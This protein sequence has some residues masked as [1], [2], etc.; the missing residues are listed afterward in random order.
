MRFL[1]SGTVY[2]F[3]FSSSRGPIPADWYLTYY[4]FHR[5][6]Q[7]ECRAP[8]PRHHSGERTRK[9]ITSAYHSLSRR[10]ERGDGEGAGRARCDVGAC[11]EARAVPARAPQH[12]GRGDSRKRRTSRTLINQTS[13]ML[14]CLAAQQP[15]LEARTKN[16]TGSVTH[17]SRSRRQTSSSCS[18]AE[19]TD[20]Q[21]PV[22]SRPR[23]C[24][25]C[26]SGHRRRSDRA[27]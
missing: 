1:V 9:E 26:A 24:I 15:S 22:T 16:S 14:R 11:F 13:L 21:V 2:P 25:K 27:P 17:R 6:R 10:I 18:G 20:E 19:M 4:A 3:S 7:L 23:E 8:N 12:E 5:A